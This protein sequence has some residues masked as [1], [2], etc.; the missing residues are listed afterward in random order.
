MFSKQTKG[1]DITLQKNQNGE[2]TGFYTY[3][4]AFFARHGK[5]IVCAAISILVINTVNSIETLTDAQGSDSSNEEEGIVIFKMG[6]PQDEGAQLLMKS[7]L[8][9]LENIRDQYG[10]Q[11]LRLTIEEV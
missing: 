3:G 10:D 1:V 6:N 9:G 8:Q 4:H 2:Y 11:Y 5:D 7:L